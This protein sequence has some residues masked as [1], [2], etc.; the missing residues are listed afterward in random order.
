MLKFL[1]IRDFVIVDRIDLEFAPGFTVLTGETG[2]G[3]S[4]LIDALSLV[5]GERSDASA[6]RNGCERAEI[7]AG[8]EV[9][10]LPEVIA[11]LH[12]NGFENTEEEG[13]CLLRR[14]VDAGGRSRSFIN[15]NSATLQQLRAIGENLVD[16]QG[17]HVHQSMLRSEV[18]R[19]LLDSYAG[20][21]PLAR[22]VAEAYRRWQTARQQ[23]EAWEQNAAAFVR[24]REELEWQVNELSTL[25]FS[26]DEWESLQA[27]HSRLS[28]AA[29]LLA[30]AQAGL[31]A[32]SEG[33]FAVLS[34]INSVISRLHQMVDYDQTLKAV[35]DLL[36]PG[37]IQ[38]Q[39]AVYELGRYQQR[40]E[41]DPQRLSEVE[42]RLAEIH[43]AA[44]KYRVTPEELPELLKGFTERLQALGHKGDGESLAREEAV[45]SSEYSELA[46]KLTIERSGAASTLSQQ[47][48]AAM[49]TLAMA[50][51]EFSAALLP[52]EQGT[53]HGLEQIEFQVA[54]H[55]TL[56]LRP[57]AKVASGGEL[58]RIGLAISV[59]TAKLGT[60][61]TLIFDEVDVGIGGR[62]AEIVG[63]L[64][65]RLGRER[66]V[67][68]ITHLAQVASAGDQQWRVSK[69]AD[70][71][72]GGKVT[73][74]I[75]ALDRQERVEE[76]ARM[77]GGTKITD[78]TR[79]H[80]AEMLL[81]AGEADGH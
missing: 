48:T 21:K 16:I 5:L 70:S 11:W 45:A 1:G 15:G 37:Q 34:Q 20:S 31:E 75:V 30:T 22:Q 46:K 64:L 78:T 60:V 67:L 19:E 38:L 6:V 13:V 44:R 62:V 80:A 63:T 24:E 32:L 56:P 41:L 58:S 8:F 42:E 47:V 49:Q 54:A 36:E 59:I 23:R 57:L 73:S 9:A 65:K 25:N 52:L 53:L 18:Q 29:S 40:L 17:Q 43:T 71:A 72:S 55:K 27:E 28:N 7:S 66:Q 39:E 4:I 76:I 2:A 14:L 33:E 74:R 77:L 50:G 51:G 61:P 12:E 26:N 69:S 79:S 10:D 81:S 68:C 3:K 35:L